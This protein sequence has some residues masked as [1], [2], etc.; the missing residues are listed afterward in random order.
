VFSARFRIESIVTDADNYKVFSTKILGEDVLYFWGIHVP[1]EEYW[2]Y[3]Y[4]EKIGSYREFMPV[5]INYPTPSMARYRRLRCYSDTDF[6]F[7]SQ[8]WAQ[9]SLPCNYCISTG[10]NT[11]IEENSTVYPNPFNN[12]ISVFFESGGN[13]EII[14]V[15]GK[16]VYCS[17]LSFGTNEIS[18]SRFPKGIYLVKIQNKNNI[19]QVFK[20]VKS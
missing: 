10:I 17:E 19:I 16:I 13:I 3:S 12:S 11:I 8:Q 18:T 5:F 14:D 4:S 9:L 15:S 1:S 7:I 20:I 2:N 6:S